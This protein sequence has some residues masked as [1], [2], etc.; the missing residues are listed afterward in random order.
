MIP[1]IK[2]LEI[3]EQVLLDP[4]EVYEEGAKNNKNFY[5]FYRLEGGR[6]L[7]AVVKAVDQEAHFV[8]IYPTGDKIKNKHKGMKKVNI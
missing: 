2:L 4:T 8:T 6:Y 5:L 1:Q 7:V 3:I